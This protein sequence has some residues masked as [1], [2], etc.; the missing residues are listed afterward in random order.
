MVRLHPDAVL[1][2]C[3]GAMFSHQAELNRT[4]SV[5]GFSCTSLHWLSQISHVNATLL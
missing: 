4:G 1:V 3:N 5:R 2:E